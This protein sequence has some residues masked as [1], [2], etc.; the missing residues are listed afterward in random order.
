MSKSNYTKISNII[1]DEYMHAMSSSAFKVVMYVARKTVGWNKSQ[2]VISLSQFEAATGLTRKTLISA[3][4]ESVKNGWI[5]QCATSNTFAYS[6][7]YAF[8]GDYCEGNPSNFCTEDKCANGGEKNKNG[9]DFATKSVEKF[10]TQK[11]L[12]KEK[13]KDNQVVSCSLK[14][15]AP[16]KRAG[17]A[18]PPSEYPKDVSYVST[19]N[20]IQRL[21]GE[22]A[23][24]LWRSVYS[25]FIISKWVL[26]NKININ[27][28]IYSIAYAL[29]KGQN[30]SIVFNMV[31]SA[32]KA[33]PA[34]S[35]AIDIDTGK[36]EWK[37][38]IWNAFGDKPDTAFV[39]EAPFVF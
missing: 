29:E 4:K 13:T 21:L 35:C 10:H 34:W 19:E 20:E 6:L 1:F 12:T 39:E 11:T 5:E 27:V 23:L 2:D 33:L 36:P 30:P 37:R 26:E 8:K 31:K 25:R 18:S 7:G 28:I 14:P 17:D 16:P 9:G 32:P 24:L 3:I 38:F 22:E 15:P